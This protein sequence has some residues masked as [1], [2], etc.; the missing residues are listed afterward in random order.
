MAT[1]PEENK[2]L[3]NMLISNELQGKCDCDLCNE[4]PENG[5]LIQKP[6]VTIHNGQ[7]HIHLRSKPLFVCLECINFEMENS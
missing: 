5:I 2:V 1:I 4:E 6:N 3:M 7:Q